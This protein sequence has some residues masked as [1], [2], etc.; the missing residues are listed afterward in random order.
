VL[1][2]LG[3][4]V[5]AELTARYAGLV[6]PVQIRETVRVAETPSRHLPVV[7]A[8]PR[9]EIA[10]DYQLLARLLFPGEISAAGD[11]APPPSSVEMGAPSRTAATPPTTM[12]STRL[13]SRTSRVC[14]KSGRPCITEGSDAVDERLQSRKTLVRC[15]RQHPA[16]QRSI[17][18]LRGFV[19]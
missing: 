10:A 7:A 1:A 2:R 11:V 18:P 9:S 13:R 19:G 14:R 17:D 16:D 6:L 8:Q 15:Q 5:A 4:E 12:H 3:R